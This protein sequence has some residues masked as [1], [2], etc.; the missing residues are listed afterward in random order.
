MN[1]PTA[2]T[3][4]VVPDEAVDALADLRQRDLHGDGFN[5]IELDRDH[6]RAIA[7][8]VLA[9]WVEQV[10][11]KW[12]DQRWPTTPRAMAKVLRDRLAVVQP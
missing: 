7:A 3:E 12:D 11:A 6:I 4:L 8:P 1:E 5:S 10:S 9:A 2:A